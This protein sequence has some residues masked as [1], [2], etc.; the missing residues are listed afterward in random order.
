M[1]EGQNCG[2]DPT[3]IGETCAERCK[4]GLECKGE[5]KAYSKGTCTKIPGDI[6][7]QFT[8]FD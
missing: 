6:D 8:F 7:N 2:C 4:E 3:E 1:E 5:Y